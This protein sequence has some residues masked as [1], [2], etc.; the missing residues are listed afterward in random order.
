M[1]WYKI[2]QNTGMDYPKT[3][4]YYSAVLYRGI[5]PIGESTDEGWYGKGT[6]YSPQENVAKAYMENFDDSK[7]QIRQPEILKKQVVLNNP[8]V[9]TSTNY[10][11]VTKIKAIINSPEFLNKTFSKMS[12][13]EKRE[14]ISQKTT[15]LLK[16]EGHDGLILV[17]NS[18]K[19][20]EVVEF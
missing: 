9:T 14:F 3:G 16:K 12:E 7:P 5:N 6:Y 10:H 1:N 11:N 19:P 20:L 4:N 18:G 13:I 8:F 2:S 17:S 15:E